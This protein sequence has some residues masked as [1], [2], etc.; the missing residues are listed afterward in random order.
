MDNTIPYPQYT[1]TEVTNHTGHG[2]TYMV[3]NNQPIHAFANADFSGWVE[4]PLI[5]AT[6]KSR[7]ILNTVTGVDNFDLLPW[8]LI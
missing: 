7:M 6:R 3:L 2:K 4:C 1:I 5:T 8:Q